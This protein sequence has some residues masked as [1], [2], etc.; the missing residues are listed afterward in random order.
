VAIVGSDSDVDLW[1]LAALDK[2]LTAVGLAW[3]RPATGAVPTSGLSSERE[4]FRPDIPV[5]RRETSDPTAIFDRGFPLNPF[6]GT[7]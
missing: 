7:R 2:G 5:I 3:D 4:A 1:D 6:A